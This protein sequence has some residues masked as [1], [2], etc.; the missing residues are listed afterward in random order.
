MEKVALRDFASFTY[1]SGLT[2][3]ENADRL[4]FV[5]KNADWEKDAYRSSLYQVE[6]GKAKVILPLFAELYLEEG[7]KVLY[8]GKNEDE[9]DKQ[10]H[11]FRYDLK[12]G[13]SKPAFDLKCAVSEIK[14]VKRGLYL[15][16]TSLDLDHPKAHLKGEETKEEDYIVLTE[17]PF[18][19]N[20][21]GFIDRKRI[22]LYLFDEKSG[23]LTPVLESSLRLAC[24][25]LTDKG[26]YFAAD[27]GKPKETYFHD[28]YFFDFSKKKANRI[29]S[30]G[31]NVYGL[32]W[33]KNKLVV[34][35]SDC[36]TY[37]LN[38]N[39][40]FYS[41]APKALRL[42]PL[43]E[44]DDNC[45]SWVGS[46]IHMGDGKV[47]KEDG[48]TLYYLTTE[49]NR[50]VIRAIDPFGRISTVAD[51]EG[52]I[53]DF[54]VSKGTLYVLA[55]Y[56]MKGTELYRYEKQKPVKITSINDK[57]I[58]GKYIAK[59]RKIKV[60]SCGYDIDGWILAPMDYDAKKKYPAI[61]DIHGGPKTVYGETYY[62]E[63]QLWA[64]MG[65]FV[66]FA[67]PY[68]GDGRGDR[69][70]DLRGKYGSIDYQNLMDFVDA[71]LERYPA[72]D[73]RYIG[74]TG[75][76]Y[77]GFMTNWIVTHTK[78][79]ACAATQ[80]SISN[81]ISMAGCSDIGYAFAEDQCGGKLFADEAETLWEHSPLKF[82]GKLSTPLLII[83]S[84]EDYRCPLEQGLQMYSAA[85]ERK[86]DAKMVIFKGENHE[87]SRSG[88]PSHRQRR[89]EE[90]TNWF[91]KYLKPKTKK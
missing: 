72:I 63:M 84:N 39:P 27:K 81:W 40:K 38:E 65:Y 73:R 33:W 79:F 90:I 57:A 70:S 23:T 44:N 36:Q 34:W 52:A 9:K 42:V 87:L 13:E 91:E 64:S 28:L 19:F 76:S 5:A 89:L 29:L 68:G 41:F 35:G 74:V 56:G 83:H 21:R 77:G 6:N 66:M 69:F 3:S 78:R 24:Y 71:V 43:A 12:T 86:V 16:S 51:E 22:A 20:G 26:V 48:E 61:L 60:N 2:L 85:L 54:D 4:Y 82:A 46:D 1:L 37:G 32:K 30:T 11:F 53:V 25:E 58:K 50:S 45:G 14:R 59:P 10:S 8:L 62:H 17:S 47:W 7:E 55:D 88:K 67:N 31:L 80:R 15:V 18:Y 75:G 49:R